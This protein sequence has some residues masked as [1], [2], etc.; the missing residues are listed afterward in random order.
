MELKAVGRVSMGDLGLEVRGKVDDGDGAKGALLRADT[1]SYTQRLGQ[2]GK[3]G[4]GRD[5]DAWRIRSASWEKW[6]ILG[7]EETDRACRYAR[8]DTTSC[9]LDDISA[10][11]MV[12]IQRLGYR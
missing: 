12:S 7:P 3:T 8:R 11:T 9:I 1:A 10:T 5:L 4:V 6:R 2:E